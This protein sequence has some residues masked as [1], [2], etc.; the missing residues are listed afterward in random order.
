MFAFEQDDQWSVYFNRA[1]IILKAAEGRKGRKPLSKPSRARVIYD[2]NATR[3]QNEA[4]VAG[5]KS[6]TANVTY[7]EHPPSIAPF[8]TLEKKYLEDLRLELAHRGSYVI[9]R[10]VVDPYRFVSISTIAEDENGE[11]EL[12]QIY[13]QDD[14][15]LPVSV[16]PEGQVF[17]VKEPFFKTT[18]LGGTSI[19]VDHVSDIIFLDGEDERIPEKWR[20][21]LRLLARRPLDWKEDGNRFYGGKQ[22]FEAAR[23]YTKGLEVAEPYSE[24]E[25]V[26]LLNRAQAYLELGYTEKALVDADKVLGQDPLNIKALYRS[27]VSCYEDGDYESA[28]ARLV[29]LLKEYPENKNA[30]DGLLRTFRRLREQRSGEYEF[31]KMRNEVKEWGNKKGKLDCAEYVGPVRVGHAG[32]KGR[33]L[34]TTRD[35][36]FGELLLCSK[37]FKVCHKEAEGARLAILFNFKTRNGQ[38]GTHSQLVQELIQI[39]YHN[40]K[41]AKK[42]YELTSGDYERVKGEMVDG[43]PIVD[44]HLVMRIMLKNCFG[45]PRL[46][47][48]DD[49]LENLFKDPTKEDKMIAEASPTGRV[50]GSGIWIL[51]SYMN[52]SCWANSVRSFLGDLLIVRAARDIPEGEEITTNYLQTDHPQSE[53]RVE[54]RQKHFRSQ[55]AFECQCTLCEVETAES[56]EVKDKR[57]ELVEKAL[58]F[59]VY[60]MQSLTKAGE[61]IEPMIKLVK[62][63]EATYSTP[64]FLYPRVPLISPSHI[65]HSFL[66]RTQRPRDV[67]ALAKGALNGLGFKIQLK[68]GK[69]VIE[70]YGYLSFPIINLFVHVI[71]AGAMCDQRLTAMLWRDLTINV[72]E[73]VAGE[74]ESF[75]DVY[76]RA[77]LQAGVPVN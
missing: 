58:K 35:V 9:L 57:E 52:H 70:R 33:G 16:V 73:V 51:P 76:G 67:L 6:I 69:L 30:K 48:R 19:R 71:T 53:S 2:H 66:A 12:V 65:L 55:W 24:I 63:I 37:A 29:K 3:S 32:S 54:K 28:K 13:N 21:R 50:E 25:R 43:L 68:A 49:P 77:L 41:K 7:N 40:P 23:C 61:G 31:A 74:R 59:K 34:F 18:S 36:K 60:L 39:L 5:T 75:F 22:Y 44:S 47:A 14:R 45:C 72:Y 1:E 46:N 27:A 42:V 11:V 15:R 56:D 26:L 4:W 17:I 38:S 10:A 8:D 62:G 64:E 20:P